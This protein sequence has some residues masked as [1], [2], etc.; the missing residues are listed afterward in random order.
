MGISTWG[1][2]LFGSQPVRADSDSGAGHVQ[3][4]T[5]GADHHYDGGRASEELSSWHQA[6]PGKR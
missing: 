6:N 1:A 4:D 5:R 2:F 3:S